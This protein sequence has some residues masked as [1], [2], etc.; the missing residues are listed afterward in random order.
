MRRSYLATVLGLGTVITLVGASGIYAAFTDRATTG[1]NSATSGER[2]RA[3]NLEVAT[4]GSSFGDCQT[5]Q[6]DLTTGL[7]AM[8]NVQ[9]GDRTSAFLC[10]KNAGSSTLTTSMTVIDLID[11]EAGCTGDEAAA[12]DTTC[13]SGE[14]EIAQVLAVSLG[15]L[16]C[17]TGSGTSIGGEWL[18][19]LATG[20]SF[21]LG[22]LAP[23]DVRCLSLEVMYA[24]NRS[25]AE[26][27]IAQSDVVT[28]RFAFDGVSV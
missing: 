19:S 6:D 11:Q 17:G 15:V 26:V 12:G 25:D 4:T 3:A 7:F 14:G 9:P 21:S 1:P 28:W 16:D 20:T 8:S 27:L 10:L 13:G 5:F 18:S 22:S 23:G 24:L 2:P